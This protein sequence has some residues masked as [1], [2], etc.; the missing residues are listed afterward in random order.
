MSSPSS[1]IVHFATALVA[2][3]RVSFAKALITAA[4]VEKLQSRQKTPSVIETDKSKTQ[5]SARAAVF[6][7]K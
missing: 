5:A 7:V 3:R 1:R 4:A 6:T 2:H